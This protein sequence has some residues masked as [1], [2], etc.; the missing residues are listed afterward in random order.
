MRSLR[1]LVASS[2]TLSL[3][4][5]TLLVG[6]PAQTKA[7][8]NSPKATVLFVV[9]A[10]QLPNA[11][12]VPFLII[13]GGQ[14]KQPIAG[15][16][17]AA[18][19]ESF[20]REHYSKGRKYRVLF[21]G[22]EAGS[23][24]VTKSNKDEE[25]ARTSADV[26]L[27]SQAKLNRN[28][29]ALATNSASLG[30]GKNTRRPPTAA[31]RAALMPLVQAA[32]KQKGLAASLL[33][34]LVTVNLTALDLNNDGKAELVG[35]FVVKK[36]KGGAERYALFLIA[37]PQGN[38]YRTTVLQYEKFVEKDIM[39]GADITIIENGVYLERL[40]D[41]LDFDGD[42]ASEVIT[43]TDGL[44]GDSYSIYKKQDGKW[45]KVYEFGNYRCG[46]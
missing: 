21:G 33:P 45:N 35:S 13:E 40:V 38:S 2:L 36:Q 20:S 41:G 11:S 1:T 15:D 3:L 25:C 37:E 7:Q 22:S 6:N 29:M 8:D 17:D 39:S 43:Q 12:V 18:E 31:E 23:L 34:G 10:L 5:A 4:L 27:R 32:Y 16:S 26:T 30:G 9:S 42:G 28:V 19:I 44:E 46:F 14:F 24:T